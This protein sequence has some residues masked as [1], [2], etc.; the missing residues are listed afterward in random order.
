M[1]IPEGSRIPLGVLSLQ[2]AMLAAMSL[3]FFVLIP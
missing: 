2:I 1:K 3:I